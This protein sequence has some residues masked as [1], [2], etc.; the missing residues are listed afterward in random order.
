MADRTVEHLSCSDR[1][2]VLLRRL[3]EEQNEQV[4]MGL[5]P[6]CVYRDPGHAVIDTNVGEGVRQLGR[7]RGGA[8]LVR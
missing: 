7:S 5:D 4:Q 3:L 6:M 1:G 2:V 8:P